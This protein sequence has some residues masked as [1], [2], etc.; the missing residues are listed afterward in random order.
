MLSPTERHEIEAER[1]AHRGV[2]FIA[3]A[4]Y[5]CESIERQSGGDGRI[6]IRECRAPQWTD[7][8]GFS[9]RRE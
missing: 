4:V 3:Y 1:I 7:G 8:A 9:P 2:I 6:L 5:W